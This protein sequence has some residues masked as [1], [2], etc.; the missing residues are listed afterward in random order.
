LSSEPVVLAG[1]ADLELYRDW[2]EE[3]KY[4]AVASSMAV[5]LGGEP[6]EA[7]DAWEQASPVTHFES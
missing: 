7:P 4:P 2:A 3:T 6:W 5:R 1:L